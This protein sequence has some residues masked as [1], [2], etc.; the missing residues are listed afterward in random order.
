MIG[1][2]KIIDGLFIGDQ[3]ASTVSL[4]PTI[5]LGPWVC[6]CKQS[7]S[8]N[9]LRREVD[10]EP[11]GG[12]RRSLFDFLLAGPRQL[13]KKTF[14]N[15]NSCFLTPRTR[16]LTLFLTLL[17]KPSKL[18]SQF[19]FTRS[20]VRAGQRVRLQP[21]SWGSISGRFLSLLNFWIPDDQIWK[22]EQLS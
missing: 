16:L 5:L 22:S 13:G 7:H 14:L 10:S 12:Y 4:S 15:L 2:I 8:C 18:L 11:L 6:S 3:L 17:K 1:A 9:Q 20:E 21:T 19:L